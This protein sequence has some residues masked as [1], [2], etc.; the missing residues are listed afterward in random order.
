MLLL[1]VAAGLVA[2]AGAHADRPRPGMD[3]AVGDSGNGQPMGLW[4][5]G[6]TVWVS[7]GTDV[8]LYAYDLDTGA[9]KTGSEFELSANAS[10]TG[11]W[12]EGGT[13]WVLDYFGGAY[14]YDLASG[15]RLPDADL[16]YLGGYGALDLHFDGGTFW[17][18]HD[19]DDAVRAFTRNGQRDGSRDLG[20][21]DPLNASPSGVWSDGRTTWVADGGSGRRVFAYANATGERV[22][23][24]ELALYD[25][26][27]AKGMWSDGWTLWVADGVG[28][29]L[30]AFQSQSAPG[31]LT[32]LAVGGVALEVPVG[33]VRH[34]VTVG[35]D[36]AVVTVAATAADAST[37]TVR[38]EDADAEAEG[39]Q[40]DVSFGARIEVA[41]PAGPTYT[42]EVER[43]APAGGALAELA[44]DGVGVGAIGPFHPAVL[45]YEYVVA[46]DTEVVT[47]S[48]AAAGGG[49]VAFEPA[50]ADA[51][52]A[53]HHVALAAGTATV[54]TV[55]VNGSVRY[56]VRIV[57]PAAAADASL[58]SLG[59]SGVDIGVFSGA[60]TVYSATVPHATA[61]TTV[62]A[63]PA[64]ASATVEIAPADA[65]AR[66]EGHQ[67]AL[68]AET[69]VSVTVDSAD[70]TASRTY[71][72]RIERL[73]ADAAVPMPADLTRAAM[74][75]HIRRH[76]ID[77]VEAFVA[78][79]SP[80]HRRN[81]VLVFESEALFREAISHDEPRVISWGEKADMILAWT[82][83]DTAPTQTVEFLEALDDRWVAGIIDFSGS[84]PEIR[85]PATCASCHGALGKPLWGQLNRWDGTEAEVRFLDP[86]VG[87][88]NP[89]VVRSA[90]QATLRAAESV[91]PRLAPLEFQRLGKLR[92]E[93][94]GVGMVTQ[95]AGMRVATDSNRVFKL[96]WELSNALLYRHDRVLLNRLRA[97]DDYPKVAREFMCGSR[98]SDDLVVKYF[99]PGDHHLSIRS[100]TGEFIQDNE[101]VGGAPT[102]HGAYA[103]SGRVLRFFVLH[104][105]YRRDARVAAAIAG[106]GRS[107]EKVHVELAGHP[108][109]A[110]QA[111]RS[112]WISPIPA[113]IFSGDFR[114][115]Y[116]AACRALRGR[117]EELAASLGSAVAGF[118]LVDADS[119]AE[120]A[121]IRNGTV[122][123][124]LAVADRRLAARVE[125][126]GGD[127]IDSMAI[128]LAPSGS[129]VRYR[130]AA[131]TRP[132]E[133]ALAVDLAP[134][135]Y[136]LTATPYP[137]AAL[138][139]TP[140][141]PLAVRFSVWARGALTS[142]ANTAPAGLWGDGERLWVLDSTERR[143]YAYDAAT[144]ARR[145]DGDFALAASDADP[146]GLWS[147]G[148]NVW[149]VAGSRLEAYEHATGSRR[150]ELDITLD[151]QNRHA[152][153][154]WS[155]GE[156]IWVA[157]SADGQ[158]Y[159]YDLTTGERLAGYD[160]LL[161]AENSDPVDLWGDGA[162]LWVADGRGAWVYAY[163]GSGGRKRLKDREFEAPQGVERLAGLWSDGTTAWVAEGGATAGIR[164]VALPGQGAKTIV[165]GFFAP[166]GNVRLAS[167][168]L[169]GLELGFER[170]T[171]DYKLTVPAGLTR[172][173][174]EAVAPRLARVSEIEPP[175]ADA[176]T[177]GHQV[178]LPAG[179]T[180]IRVAV[181]RGV[182]TGVYEVVAYAGAAVPFELLI[183]PEEIAEQESAVLTARVAGGFTFTND[184]PIALEV[185]GES[186][187]ESDHSLPGAVTLPS[188]LE[189]IDAAFTA[190]WDREG[191]A[192]ETMTVV[193]RLGP[194]ESAPA[195]LAIS[196]N[197]AP[198]DIDTLAAAG[199][200]APSG[201]WSDGDTMWVADRADRKVYA[202]ALA[203]GGRRAEREFELTR[204]GDVSGLWS[205]GETLW[206]GDTG[207]TD[208]WLRAYA[209]TGGARL[210][211]MDVRLR[212]LEGW[213]SCCYAGFWGDGETVMVAMK[214]FQYGGPRFRKYRLRDG[215]M[216]GAPVRWDD[217]GYPRGAW[218]GWREGVGR[219]RLG[220]GGAVLNGPAEAPKQGAGKLVGRAPRERGP[221]RAAGARRAPE[222][223]LRGTVVE[224][225]DDV[226]GRRPRRQGVR[227]PAPRSLV[228]CVVDLAACGAGRDGSVRAGQ[229]GLPRPRARRR[230]TGDAVG[231]PGGRR[232]HRLRP[233]G[234][235]CRGRRL[236]GGGRVR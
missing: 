196:A 43:A 123:D 176:Q 205:N 170:E 27:A 75:G 111:A 20:T 96:S 179:F 198:P 153:G 87:E 197:E 88:G 28:G 16:G 37:V 40:V 109:E 4:S 90:R 157:D 42:I 186:V 2:A 227:L 39:H 100:D 47:V 175:D 102:Y 50:D 219:P 155:N 82:T 206:A 236:P 30:R 118:V 212:D 228:Q 138:G 48:A 134:G 223:S 6:E 156:R 187:T 215:R 74:L 121:E 124:R 68:D 220:V 202:Y 73:A 53:G 71:T 81:F 142:A 166:T 94:L 141:R 60:R 110:V 103:I 79:L 10:P 119:G 54:V 151:G 26:G 84:R 131:G 45:E 177:P 72:L 9:R 25:I 41:A 191:E 163:D 56:R 162:V 180:R 209:L 24:R 49:E 154:V 97:R 46:H 193:G 7:D 132:F 127:D 85:E 22:G 213:H 19:G 23:S 181:T 184:E 231:L 86:G 164:T 59:L 195:T 145:A 29:A 58:R 55:V 189:E 116:A 66:T 112:D 77:S 229:D 146:A 89:T 69:T 130:H 150:P 136:Y 183:E 167:L 210:E 137:G 207:G 38:P 174:V 8:K 104:D 98:Q 201:I 108:T 211:A 18:V 17:V 221:G 61:V 200:N 158:L 160:V 143:V 12:S 93:N 122:L 185:S 224:R 3:I 125:L 199:N 171:L 62:A 67:V 135:S 161:A 194:W 218:G 190:R 14:A 208:P 13:V 80:V 57:R 225:G 178:D 63:V 92:D 64:A 35:A 52:L 78:S 140:G 99:A 32:A 169:S 51:G 11:L 147:D 114:D 144:G 44:V 128:E 33:R 36:V 216:I 173:T 188:G 115:A 76:G 105:L 106:A 113:E 139:G 182:W 214:D 217:G 165:A 148:T 129:D 192:R 230:G 31:V 117:D 107:V 233:G 91:N 120:I 15:D 21:L 34:A 172:T 232:A 133:A 101:Y 235:R 70:G 1:S 152:R 168:S 83:N 234:R 159:A 149:V 203:D 5:D 126:A 95:V 222:R 226:G 204:N 65:D